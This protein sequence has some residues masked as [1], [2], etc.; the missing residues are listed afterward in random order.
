ML[1]SAHPC[2]AAPPLFSSCTSLPP[3]AAAT[4]SA[5]QLEFF[6]VADPERPKA[7]PA[8]AAGQQQQQQEQLAALTERVVSQ[9]VAAKVAEAQE[10]VA[11]VA[12]KCGLAADYSKAEETIKAV[13]ADHVSGW[14]ASRA[15]G[16]PPAS[17][18]PCTSAGG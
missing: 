3:P 1:P 7:A 15:C 18:L 11:G 17:R 10:L 13:W 5:S 12:A 8:G 9:T 4:R 16:N 2:R 6:A 14:A